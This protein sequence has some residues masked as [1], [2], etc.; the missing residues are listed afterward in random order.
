VAQLFENLFAGC[1]LIPLYFDI[2][3]FHS[4]AHT[5]ALFEALCGVF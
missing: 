5:A 4:P 1:S 2:S 3:V